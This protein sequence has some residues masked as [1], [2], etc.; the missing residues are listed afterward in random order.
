[1]TDR[2]AHNTPP[3]WSIADAI[4]DGANEVI[5][6]FDVSGSIVFVNT[7]ARTQLGYEPDALLGRNIVEF[8]HPDDHI[9]AVETLRIAAT[10]GTSR[11][12]TH[13]RLRA[14][15]GEHHGFEMTSGATRGPD[16]RPLLM[17]L[18]RPADTRLALD[19]A[20]RQLLEHRPLEDV[21][22]NTCDF[23]AWR[24]VGTHVAV[25]WRG[26][27]GWQ[28]V[29]TPGCPAV[30]SGSDMRPGLAWSDALL[31]RRDMVAHDLSEMPPAMR[32]IAEQYGRA[33]YWISPIVDAERP[34]VVSLWTL[35][36]RFPPTYH[37]EGMSLAHRFIRLVM[38]WADQ[39]DRLHRAARYDE[40]T[41][42]ANRRS[43]FDALAASPP[44]AVLY[45]DLDDFKPVNDRY[46]HSAGDEAL[47][48]V[49][50]RLRDTVRAGDTV[51]RLGGDEFGILC[52]ASTAADAEALAARIRAAVEGE[53]DLVA[54]RIRI[55]ISIG[56]AHTTDRLDAE[57][58]AAADRELYAAKAARRARYAG[59]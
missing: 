53:M 4:V 21:I 29:S 57:S 47:R 41:G 37:S 34:V 20:L 56:I 10:F 52:P 28:W 46:G 25:T 9:R 45:C 17:T 27:R 59:T 12:T 43:F 51:A 14:A 6:V 2:P 55:G 38:R 54:G 24:A 30:M 35:P 58:L 15:D 11:G 49:A 19:A 39:H 3:D 44:G 48:Q 31:E 23:F 42:L 5:T 18:S 1:M 8:V 40:L 13:F 33:G 22:F 16:G 32:A 36:H 7:A 50:V 26:D